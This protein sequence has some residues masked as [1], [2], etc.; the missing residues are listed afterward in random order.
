M[1]G[2]STLVL[3][4]VC[5]GAIAEQ[6]AKEVLYQVDKL[7][8]RLELCP[9]CLDRE[10]KLRDGHRGIP[11]MHKRAAIAF[12]V[13]SKDDLPRPLQTRAEAIDS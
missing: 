7:R 5:G 4:D 8:Y 3:C 11:G 2:H 1:K 6:T 9:P 10:M 13:S 12:S